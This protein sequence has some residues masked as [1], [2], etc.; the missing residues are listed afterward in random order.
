ME[1]RSDSIGPGIK[2]SLVRDYRSHCFVFLSKILYPLLRVSSTQED[3]KRPYMTENYMTKDQRT[4][5]RGADTINDTLST[6]LHYK[7][8]LIW[9]SSR[10]NLS[11]GFLPKRVSNQSLKLQRLARKLKFQLSQ[12]YL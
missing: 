10:E 2:G 11:L 9:A 4:G 5:P 6:T 12:V 8:H 7:D 1:K 3:K